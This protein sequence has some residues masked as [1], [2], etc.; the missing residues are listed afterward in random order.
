MRRVHSSHSPPGQGLPLRI[1]TGCYRRASRPLLRTSV[2]AIDLGRLAVQALVALVAELLG[3]LVVQRA[4]RAHR[5]VFTLEPPPFLPGVVVVLE[6]LALEELVA[7]A[8]VER[9][10]A[11][12]LPGAARRH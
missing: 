8:A 11:A 9:L 2:L 6:L 4:V 5:V 12:V 1:S 3:R 10:A 7:E